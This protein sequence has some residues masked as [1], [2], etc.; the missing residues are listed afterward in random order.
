MMRVVGKT[1]LYK[2]GADPKAHDAEWREV[3]ILSPI[4]PTGEYEIHEFS[5]IEKAKANP[6]TVSHFRGLQQDEV[7]KQFREIIEE[8]KN[9]GFEVFS[10]WSL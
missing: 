10:P 4:P 3:A 9:E 2:K 7:Q 5:G 6:D 8:R 1:V